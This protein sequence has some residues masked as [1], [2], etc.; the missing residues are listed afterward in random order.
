[1]LPTN[2]EMKIFFEIKKS[3]NGGIIC[4]GTLPGGCILTSPL[5]KH[6]WGNTSSSWHHASKYLLHNPIRV[7]TTQSHQSPTFYN[8]QS[9]VTNA[10]DMNILLVSNISI[11]NYTRHFS[12]ILLKLLRLTGSVLCCS[13]LTV[14]SQNVVWSKLWWR[15][16]YKL[17]KVSPCQRFLLVQPENKLI[18]QQTIQIHCL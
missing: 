7:I 14:S 10:G 13:W 1:M 5:T 18:Y 9:V 2:C 8:N 3:P 6:T 12:S 15:E 11:V 17:I 4:V 16:S